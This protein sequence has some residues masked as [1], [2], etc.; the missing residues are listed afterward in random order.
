MNGFNNMITNNST[1]NEIKNEPTI[2]QTNNLKSNI[3]NI[4]NNQS[5]TIANILSNQRYNEETLVNDRYH[6]HHN[7]NQY[8]QQQQQQQQLPILYTKKQNKNKIFKPPPLNYSNLNEPNFS[9]F[10]DINYFTTSFGQQPLNNNNFKQQNLNSIENNKTLQYQS[11]NSY[12]NGL[13]NKQLVINNDISLEGSIYS[14]YYHQQQMEIPP[15]TIKKKKSKSNRNKVNPNDNSLIYENFKV[16]SNNN[17]NNNYQKYQS[18]KQHFYDSN[19][20]SFNNCDDYNNDDNYTNHQHHNNHQ[21]NNHHFNG[22]NK[23]S[24]ILINQDSN[25][26]P[27]DV[28]DEHQHIST[29]P[30]LIHNIYFESLN[31]KTNKCDSDIENDDTNIIKNNNNSSTTTKTKHKPLPLVIPPN[32]NSFEQQQKQINIL[33]S[34]INSYGY[35]NVTLLK[36]PQVLKFQSNE[37]KKQYTPPPMLTPIRKGPGLFCNSNK[38]FSFSI[39]HLL[40]KPFNKSMSTSG[41]A[42]SSSSLMSNSEAINFLLSS[43]YPN[44]SSFLVCHQNNN[45]NAD[46]DEEG[47]RVGD[48][49][50]NSKFLNRSY[51]GSNYFTNSSFSLP[52]GHL[53][54]NKINSTDNEDVEDENTLNEVEC[55]ES[56]DEKE[57]RPSFSRPRLRNSLIL[58]KIKN[59]ILKIFKF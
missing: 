54:D 22:N 40:S 26:K 31:N 20:V 21:H 2:K 32:I 38:L 15:K 10:N 8:Q 49:T 51:P 28:T 45:E 43:S 42:A 30:P 39:S 24:E 47:D 36:S 13:V 19:D 34:M 58:S 1:L 29:P 25:S 33:N 48:E 57:R 27:S 56:V 11:T 53:L 6:N 35:P 12:H 7:H 14:Q 46:I 5:S 16:I 52:N 55:Q 41:E 23:I 50:K 17:N 4:N 9:K 18:K 59:I 3:N 37:I 44:H